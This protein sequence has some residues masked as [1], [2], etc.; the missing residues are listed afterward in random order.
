MNLTSFYSG[1]APHPN[2]VQTFGVSLD[3]PNPCIVLEFCG[4]GSLDGVMHDKEQIVTNET[5]R[6]Y[7]LKIAY[8]LILATKWQ[9][10]H[11][12]LLGT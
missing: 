2:L 7:A 5:K 3:G 12:I 10:T 1:I 8:E 4:G 9:Y 11:R 6:S